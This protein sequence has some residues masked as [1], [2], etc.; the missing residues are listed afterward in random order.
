VRLERSTDRSARDPGVKSLREEFESPALRLAVHCSGGSHPGGRGL[1]LCG[2]GQYSLKLMD[3]AGE[4]RAPGTFAAS[5]AG[6]Q[7]GMVAVLWMVAWLG[8]S[9]AWQRRSFWTPEN[10]LASTFYGASA[11]RR[12]FSGS[13]LS[14]LALYL[15]VYSVL[16]CLFAAAVR[17]AVPRMRR[18]LLAV[19]VAVA[20]YYLSFHVI[21]KS[22]SPLVTLLHPEEPTI[23][24][25]VLFGMILA[26]FPRYLPPVVS[27]M[28]VAP[29]P[30]TVS[31]VQ[32]VE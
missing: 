20:W 13:T 12:G 8:L 29:E 1:L 28:A 18:I 14:G 7:A 17:G 3:T 15:L 30:D 6:L 23:L 2:H 19:V 4:K 10:L 24:G 32:P 5:L 11:I 9:S 31:A 27:A 22:L 21:W 25:H 16:G 26:R